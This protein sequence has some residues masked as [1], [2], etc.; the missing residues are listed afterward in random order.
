M[1]KASINQR[2]LVL[3]TIW[4]S[5]A[6]LATGLVLT[7]MFENH[8]I[9]E[10]EATLEDQAHEILELVAVGADGRISL[11][12]HPIDPRFNRVRSGWYW[13]AVVEGSMAERSRSLGADTLETVGLSRRPPEISFLTPDAGSQP[14]RG[15]RR[16][17]AVAGSTK[18]V[19]VTVTGPAA[20]VDRSVR[21]FTGTT[22]FSL[23]ALGIGLVL[24]LMLQV[25]F[26]LKPLREIPATL[27]GIRA[28]YSTR[29]GGE[30]P[31]EI[32]PLVDE[33]NA[34][35]E[36]NAALIDRARTQ[37]GNLA[38]SLKSPLTVLKNLR[39]PMSAEAGEVLERQIDLMT[40]SVD[41][42]VSRARVAGGD[43]ALGT[44]VEVLPVV[45]GLRRMFERSHARRELEFSLGGLEGLAFKGDR[46]DL[47]EMLGNLMDNACKWTRRRIEI[48][49]TEAQ[50]RLRLTVHDDGDGIAE[51]EHAQVL[52]RGRR[53]DET[54]PGSGLGLSIVREVA[55]LH[56][57]SLHLGR[58]PL[59]GLAATLDLPPA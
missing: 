52:N 26:G 15:I 34:L 39:E 53:L 48:S 14:L 19:N 13:Q 32:T 45:D 59:G 27:A 1:S 50:G 43:E 44:R 58:S 35:L 23:A 5:L 25:K 22:V 21:D 40:D 55:E 11:K 57:G 36:R 37:A 54:V 47:E 3:G 28:G 18:V 38:H 20:V 4:T 42:H 30:F 8:V 10:F 17:L 2:L 49:G 56:D 6:L 12:R 51:K 41:W 31:D 29:L 33:L 46:H 9:K 16:Q 24:G 7:A